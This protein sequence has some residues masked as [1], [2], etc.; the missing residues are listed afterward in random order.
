[1]VIFKSM[2]YTY[3]FEDNTLNV[4][5]LEAYKNIGYVRRNVTILPVKYA[6]SA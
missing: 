1:M 5:S 2:Q 6:N 4:M 3:T